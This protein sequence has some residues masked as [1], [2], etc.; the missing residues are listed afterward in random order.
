MNAKLRERYK[1]MVIC[2]HARQCGNQEC[3]HGWPHPY[4]NVAGCHCINCWY[5]KG[6][7]PKCIPFTEA[8]DADRS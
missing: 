4:E 2:D 5:A 7:T 8:A 6:V 1:D 3:H